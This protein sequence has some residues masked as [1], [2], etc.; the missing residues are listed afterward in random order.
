MPFLVYKQARDSAWARIEVLVSTKNGEVRVPVM[1]RQGNVSN[2]VSEIP[3][4]DTTLNLL[5]QL[6]SMRSTKHTGLK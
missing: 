1:H 6:I 3:S 4:T 2:G 5:G